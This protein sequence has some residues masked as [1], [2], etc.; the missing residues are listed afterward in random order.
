LSTHKYL[1]KL[2]SKMSHDF[3]V[4]YFQ[5]P[6]RA[7]CRIILGS[8]L[9]S[10]ITFA[11]FQGILSTA[12]PHSSL[13]ADCWQAVYGNSMPQQCT[14]V[15]RHE[16]V[17]W[18]DAAH[19]PNN[20]RLLQVSFQIGDEIYASVAPLAANETEQEYL[21]AT[22]SC[23]LPESG[24][25][26]SPECARLGCANATLWVGPPLPASSHRE[27]YFGVSAISCA[28]A[29]AVLLPVCIIDLFLHWRKV[30]RLPI[31]V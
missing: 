7:C 5:S 23:R 8:V 10:L 26:L 9:L 14:I 3:L 20:R 2:F 29:A 19:F 11:A 22:L 4:G 18:N 17:M 12:Q 27:K 30:K 15:A 24:I 6:K 28:I 21:N 25:T 1:Q 16:Q 13:V 31:L